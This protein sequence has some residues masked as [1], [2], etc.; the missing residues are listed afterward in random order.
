MKRVTQVTQVVK[1]YAGGS[2]EAWAAVLLYSSTVQCST[3]VQYSYSINSMVQYN[4]AV[5][6]GTLVQCNTVYGYFS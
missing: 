6:Y 4:G 1:A 3:V 2:N 5:V